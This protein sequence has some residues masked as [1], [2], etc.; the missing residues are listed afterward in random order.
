MSFA[1]LSVDLFNSLHFGYELRLQIS[2]I[3]GMALVVI[4]Q[5]GEYWVRSAF[6]RVLGERGKGFRK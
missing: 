6:G 3:G 1:D 5:G 4:R 2:N